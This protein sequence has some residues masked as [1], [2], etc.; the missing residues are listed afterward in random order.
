MQNWSAK[1][2][3]FLEKLCMKG[4]FGEKFNDLHS[5]LQ[6]LCGG[7]EFSLKFLALFA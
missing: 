3:F 5:G 6:Q 2:T 7:Q 1:K 4:L